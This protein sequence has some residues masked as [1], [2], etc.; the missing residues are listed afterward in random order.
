MATLSDST[1][2]I[3]SDLAL[4]AFLV[5]RGLPL[6]D[7]SRNQGKFEFIFNDANS[8]AVKLSIEFVNSEF[9]KFDNHVRTLKKILYRS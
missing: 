4:A 6:I 1:K 2:H 9:S 3:T 7:A 8:E 5:M